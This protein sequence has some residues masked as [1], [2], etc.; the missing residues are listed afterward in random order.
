MKKLRTLL[1]FGTAIALVL[2]ASAASGSGTTDNFKKTYTYTQGKFLDVPGTA[3]FA[4]YVKEAYEYGAM[5]GISETYFNPTGNLSIAEAITVACWLNTTYYYGDDAIKHYDFSENTV[6]YL[7]FV[8][9]A[10][11]NGIIGTQYDELYEKEATR[12]DFAT[13]IE[14]SLP[15]EALQT[16]NTIEGGSIPDVPVGSAYYDAVYHLYRAGIISGV[17]SNGSFSPA[18]NIT[19]AEMAVILRNIVDENNRTSFS[20]SVKPTVPE[21]TG[22]IFEMSDSDINKAI[23]DGTADFATVQ[24]MLLAQY[25]VPLS[26]INLINDYA[27]FYYSIIAQNTTVSVITPACYIKRLSAI[28][29]MNFTTLNFGQAKQQYESL[30]KSPELINIEINAAEDVYDT[31]ASFAVGVRQ[32]GKIISNASIS[33]LKGE[34]P[35]RS[36]SWPDTPSYYRIINVEVEQSDINI[37]EPIELVIRYIT[38]D[39]LIY[40]INLLNYTE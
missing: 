18:K 32:N 7:P 19:R 34:F 6:W 8:N 30:F 40:N 29:Y 12:A 17:D 21:I 4:P 26:R 35:E 11:E 3:W 9:Y 23:V 27:D 31:N 38:G 33:G 36:A 22:Y 1:A 20:I 16:I 24:R 13:I 25:S 10:Q 5:T 39:E 14:A 37:A 2:P 28:N 15:Y